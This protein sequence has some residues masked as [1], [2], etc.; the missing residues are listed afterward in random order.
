MDTTTGIALFCALIVMEPD[1]TRIR[2]PD[3]LPFV[4]ERPISIAEQAQSLRE[5]GYRAQGLYIPEP[6]DIL[7]DG[8]II[9]LT[10]DIVVHEMC[11]HV[12]YRDGLPFSEPICNVAQ[13][14]AYQCLTDQSA[15][16]IPFFDWWMDARRRERQAFSYYD[17]LEESLREHIPSEHFDAYYRAIGLSP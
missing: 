9:A 8:V 3:L 11:H 10:W 14:E 6:G 5:H 7:Y 15:E 17:P 13:A 4:I 16:G 2:I 12:Q 1:S